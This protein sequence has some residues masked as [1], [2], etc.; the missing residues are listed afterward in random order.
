MKENGYKFESHSNFGRLHLVED[1]RIIL[2]SG[3]A[4]ERYPLFTMIN[5][6]FK[7]D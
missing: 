1:G 2:T 6:T 7:K 3:E 5:I 4:R